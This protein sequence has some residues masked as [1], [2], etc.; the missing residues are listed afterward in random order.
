MTP[1]AMLA[2]FSS[3]VYVSEKFYPHEVLLYTEDDG[4]LTPHYLPRDTIYDEQGFIRYEIFDLYG[5]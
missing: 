1:L 3:F 2:L 4:S 5:W